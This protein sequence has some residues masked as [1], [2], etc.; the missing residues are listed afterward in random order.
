MFVV[1]Y[2]YLCRHAQLI[3]PFGGDVGTILPEDGLVEA[4]LDELFRVAQF[5]E[6]GIREQ[7]RKVNLQR[8]AGAERAEQR[9]VAQVLY[10]C[11]CQQH[12]LVLLFDF[13]YFLALLG[14]SPKLHQLCLVP[15]DEFVDKSMTVKRC[16]SSRTIPTIS[17]LVCFFWNMEMSCATL[18]VDM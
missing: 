16:C 7:R 1:V 17:S 18:S 4:E 8:L 6:G 5:L 10:I 9:I 13:G 14:T 11:N 12:S 2:E 15:V 3:E